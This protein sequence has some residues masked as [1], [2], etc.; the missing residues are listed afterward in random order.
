MA[1]VQRA[2]E[3]TAHMSRVLLEDGHVPIAGRTVLFTLGTGISAQTCSGITDATGTAAFIL[4]R[5]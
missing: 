2:V 4:R 5:H 3:L 1:V